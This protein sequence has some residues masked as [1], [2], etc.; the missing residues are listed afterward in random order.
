MGG[1]SRGSATQTEIDGKVAIRLTGEV[2][3]KNNG[4]FIQIA[5]DLKNSGQTFDASFWTGIK[6][7]VFGNNEV[8]DIRLRTDQIVRPWQSFRKEFLAKK[9]WTSIRLPFFNFQPHRIE[10][11]LDPARLR[12]IGVLAI[13]RQMQADISVARVELYR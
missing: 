11:T 5:F 13:G 4:G 10:E 3:L 8:Y 7:N 2:S 9:E 1:L 6:L 12:R